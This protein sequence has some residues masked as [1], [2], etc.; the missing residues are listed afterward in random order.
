MRFS[1]G[2]VTGVAVVGLALASALAPFG[3]AS[4]GAETASSDSEAAKTAPPKGV[5]PPAGHPLAKVAMNMAPSQVQEVMGTPTN[6][7]SYITGKMFIPWYFGSDSGSRVEYAYKGQG[8]VV[9]AV[10]RWSGQQNVV[11][12]DYDPNEDGL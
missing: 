10:N 4:D 7:K 9:F 6:Q 11:R 1:N 3:C 2:F 12:V 5:A 8:R